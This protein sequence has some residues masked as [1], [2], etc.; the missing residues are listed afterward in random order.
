MSAPSTN[1]AGILQIA[2]AASVPVPTQSDQDMSEVHGP[3]VRTAD[4]RTGIVSS[5]LWSPTSIAPDDS[6]ASASEGRRHDPT[7]TYGPVLLQQNNL[8][9]V[10]VVHQHGL[11]LETIGYVLQHDLNIY[12]R[13]LEGTPERTYRFSYD[14][15]FRYIDR[16]RTDRNRE[17]IYQSVGGKPSPSVPAPPSKKYVPKGFCISCVRNGSCKK[18][19]CKYKHEMPEER[20]RPRSKSRPSRPPTR[21][22]SPSSCPDKPRICRFYKQS[23]CNKGDQCKILHTGKPGA[24]ATSGSGS[25]KSGSK[26]RGKGRRRRKDSSRRPRSKGSRTSKS[27]SQG[28]KGSG[29]KGNSNKPRVPA[30][31][32]LLGALIAASTSTPAD[33]ASFAFRKEVPDFASP[34]H[35]ASH[36]ALP[37]VRFNNSPDHVNIP[38][39]GEARQVH[40]P[41]RGC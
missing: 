10:A 29:S 14:A 15:A 16:K 30:A 8:A 34:C 37:V 33:A 3:I 2:D 20:G 32:C 31:V 19:G 4:F 23:R 24:V 7:G 6:G 41:S 13:A 18:D 28:S 5:S 12:E 38:L 27:S 26:G 36:V 11:P 22:N 21:E 1:P 9:N 25:S 17:R 40:T 39:R 35:L